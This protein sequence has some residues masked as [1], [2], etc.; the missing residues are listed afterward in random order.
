[1]G[2][3]SLNPPRW[4]EKL[5]SRMRKGSEEFSFLGDIR[6]EY[7]YIY[8]EKGKRKAC[9]WYWQQV[10]INFPAFFKDS[11]YWSAQMLKNYFI[12]TLRNIKRNRG[13]SFIN[14]TGLAIGMAACLLILLWVR[15]ELSFN[16]FHKNGENIYLVLSERVEHRGEF[17]HTTPVPL[18]EPLEND[19]PEIAKVV[20]FQFRSELI[21]RHQESVFSDWKGAY[22]DP[23]VFD[24]FTF[25]FSKGD[26]KSAFLELNSIVLTETS[27]RKLFPAVD[28]I[29]QMMEIEDDLVVVA[30]IL[31]DIP[32]NS[33]IQFDF[34]RPFQSMNELTRFRHFIW[35]WFAC[36]TY[37]QLKDGVDHATVN[38]KI[39]DLLNTNR[40]WSDDPLRVFLYPFTDHHLHNVGGGGPIKYV[41]IFTVVALLILTIA[42]INFMNLSTAR[43][44][45]RAKEVG[46]R[47]VVGSKRLQLIKQFFLESAFFAILSAFVALLLVRIFV[48]LFNQLTGK[49]LQID[50]SDLGLIIGLIGM[51]IFTGVA[52][53]SYPA[54]ILSSFQPIDVLKGNLLLQKVNCKNTSV[55]GKR[56]RQGMVM[57]QFVLSIGLIVCA[58]VVFRQL[59]YMRNAD[60]G[61]DKDNLVRVSIP[62]KYGDKYG[63]LKSDFAQ[64]SNIISISATSSENHGG[65]IDWDGASGDMQYLGTNTKYQMVDFDYITTHKMDIMQGRDF[66]REFP[67][68]MERA[69][70]INEEAIRRWEI[71]S[72]VDRRFALNAAQGTI[73][74]V[75][76]NQHFGL[77][78]DVMPK[79]LYLTS[80][81]D[82][83][84]FNYLVIRLKGHHIPEALDHIKKI[85]KTHIPDIPIEYHFVDDMIDA[86]YQSEER[87]SKLISTFTLLAV[88]VSCLGLFGMA[89][90]MAQQRTK[91]IGIRK[92]L[93]AS[94]SRII[95]LLTKEFTRLVLIA[96]IVAWPF[97]YY[98]MQNW[99]NDYP[100]RIK[101]GFEVFLISGF[102][103]L[104]ISVLTV[105]FQAVRAAVANPADSLRYE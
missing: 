53:G 7:S 72:P 54:L 22:V 104:V 84:R 44:T 5:L 82:W 98:A 51:A 85:W 97:A 68:D 33:D 93:G 43:S 88:V 103:A 9:F 62:E 24:V 96:N 92:V 40:P 47:K 64:S 59:Q 57:T 77:K 1:M 74:G 50:L 28:P 81:T 18:A 45:K 75:F 89:S 58:L 102:A 37:V 99:L 87:L 30:G 86:L 34:L 12:I 61:F 67:S 6:E 2:N 21:V 11:L 14:I 41:Y 23:E 17:F 49:Q 83:D 3:I 55:T 78:H 35:N 105:I 4:A 13:F 46:L 69:Y 90:F 48:P 19:Y 52:A 25:P 91:E 29:G 79:V 32:D 66:S 65:R 39:A 31:R 16:R 71:E 100:Y 101:I 26:P 76:K 8:S 73:I 20:R 10:L 15:D 36:T 60:L 80:K 56:F 63:I 27:A 42:C 38:P 94:V 95:V 70:L